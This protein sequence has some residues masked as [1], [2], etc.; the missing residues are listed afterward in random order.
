MAQLI[1]FVG[2]SGV[3]KTTL[4]HTLARQHDFALGLESHAE[5]PFQSL[6]QRDRRYA[7]VNQLDYLL[8]RSEQER[9]LRSDPRLALIDGGLDLDFHGFTRL[10]HARGW[11]TDPE[12]HLLQRF[13]TLT[14]SLLPLPE[15]I[16]Y[17]T[18]SP[19]VIRARLTSRQR[20]NIA[21]ADDAPLLT[22]FLEEWLRSLPTE[23]VLHLDVSEE[24]PD[25][26]QSVW[27][28]LERVRAW[29]RGRGEGRGGK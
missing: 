28:V 13:Y 29:E 16:V 3:G 24:P 21:T 14:R 11:L 15:L 17:L 6:F 23:R 9:Q 10:F 7:L 4:V 22:L 26:R 20:I 19:E 8:Y 25:Y 1:C 5:R 12:L 2:V 27:K 18:A